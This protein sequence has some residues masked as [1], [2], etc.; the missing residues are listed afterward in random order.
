VKKKEIIEQIL[1]EWKAPEGQPLSD[2]WEQIQQKIGASEKKGKTVSMRT[3]LI[4][5]AAAAAVVALM[6]LGPLSDSGTMKLV[7]AGV[8]KQG[9]ELPDGSV[10]YL[11]GGSTAEYNAEGWSE[12]RSVD[13]D[14]EAYFD[15]EK[16]S[17]FVVSTGQGIVQVL[18]TT[19]NVQHRGESFEVECYSGKVSVENH[20]EEKILNPGEGVRLTTDGLLG[21]SLETNN[22]DW[23]LGEFKFVDAEAIKVFEELEWQLGM[24]INLPNLD[25][26]KF[27]GDFE[28]KDPELAL[29]TVCLALGLQHKINADMSVTVTK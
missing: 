3:W 1:A 2:S 4:A 27:T 29:S 10:I 20:G 5:S 14:G 13:L 18:G 17:K 26:Y 11:N 25:G 8:V 9:H 22:P 21:Y 23:K 24:E 19:F 15:V 16:G 7:A 12:E 6:F 28:T